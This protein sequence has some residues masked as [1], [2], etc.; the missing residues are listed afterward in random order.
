MSEPAVDGFLDRAKI[1]SE[2]RRWVTGVVY[3]RVMSCP[4]VTMSSHTPLSRVHYALHDLKSLLL[5]LRSTQD[6][7]TARGASLRCADGTSPRVQVISKLTFAFDSLSLSD[8][9]LATTISLLDRLWGV[10][11][12]SEVNADVRIDAVVVSGMALKMLNV[13]NDH[14]GVRR[15]LAQDICK[16]IVPEFR[17][18]V[19]QREFKLL[20]ALA[21]YIG[22]PT[23]NA[24]ADLLAMKCC[25]VA[26]DC[27]AD[28]MDLQELLTQWPGWAKGQLVGGVPLHRFVLLVSFFVE[29]GVC[30]VSLNDLGAGNSLHLLS[31]AALHL[32]SQVFGPP[33]RVFAVFVSELI[34]SQL[35]REELV[36]LPQVIS[37]LQRQWANPQ[38][39]SAVVINKWSRR[40]YAFGDAFPDASSLSHVEL[41]FP[42]EEGL[43]VAVIVVVVVVAVEDSRSSS[44]LSNTSGSSSSSR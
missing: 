21:S 23:P 8:E 30:V 35:S 31:I 17:H 27:A 43:V 9:V 42:A 16:V 26:K 15:K 22:T 28:S 33:P 11:P 37:E 6:A 14:C 34:A 40:S 7:S 12:I 10:S 20:K 18:K 13:N 38:T 5:R 29:L 19:F 1:P 2:C 24:I 25:L 44:R 41:A 36:V 39:G 3:G 4:N 32:A